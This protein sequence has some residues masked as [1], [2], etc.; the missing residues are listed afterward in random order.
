MIYKL[1]CALNFLFPKKCKLVMKYGAMVLMLITKL[2]SQIAP[3]EGAVPAPFYVWKYALN[4]HL[5]CTKKG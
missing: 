4:Y 2:T 1:E 5:I 3:L